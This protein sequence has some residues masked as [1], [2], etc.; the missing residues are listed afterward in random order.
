MRSWA[1]WRWVVCGRTISHWL[2]VAD[3]SGQQ[4]AVSSQRG[5][6]S[7]RRDQYMKEVATGTAPDRSFTVAAQLLSGVASDSL[8]W[9]DVERTLTLSTHKMPPSLIHS[10]HG[11]LCIASTDYRWDSAPLKHAAK[12]KTVRRNHNKRHKIWQCIFS[13]WQLDSRPTP[14]PQA[15]M[16]AK[17]LQLTTDRTRSSA[18]AD[19]PGR[20]DVRNASNTCVQ[21]N[22]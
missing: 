12:P 5:D 16:E 15:G 20:R 8:A 6:M 14:V 3:V 18:D 4:S 21:A 10:V 22:S 2:W 11:V 17:R 1:Q 7:G 13:T 19:K 9:V